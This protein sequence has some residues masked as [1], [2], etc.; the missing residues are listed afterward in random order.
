MLLTVFDLHGM[1]TSMKLFTQTVL[2]ILLATVA[3]ASTYNFPLNCITNNSG[4]CSALQTQLNVSA[5]DNGSQV[6]YTFSNFGPL[7]A[8]ISEIYFTDPGG[9]LSLAA[10][11]FTASSPG[12][13]FQIGGTPPELPAGNTVGFVTSFHVTAKNPSPNNGVN[14]NEFLSVT[15]NITPG[16]TF[17]QALAAG[18][19]AAVHVQ[20]FN[21]FS[22]SL[23]DAVPAPVPEPASY[24][25]MGLGLVGLGLFGRKQY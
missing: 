19:L 8:T 13:L 6:T 16:K 17:D 21:G 18:A 4:N 10:N 14:V 22:E 25:L 15:L 3:S 24:A 11:P 2:F 20:E 23:V 5:V 9:F 1:L 12:V 7:Q